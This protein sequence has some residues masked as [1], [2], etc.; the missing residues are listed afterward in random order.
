MLDECAHYGR[1]FLTTLF[2]HMKIFLSYTRSKDLF[3]KISSFRDR[4][5]AEISLRSPGAVV[6]QDKQHL[7]EGGHFPEVLSAELQGADV[8]VPIISPA[9]F[10]SDWCRREFSIFTSDALDN[11]RLHK[12][13]PVL[14]VD[15]PGMVQRSL[16]V[17]ARVLADISY[18]DWRDLRHEEWTS[19]KTQK[20]ISD[21]AES[22]I[23]LASSQRVR[24]NSSVGTGLES[25]RFKFGVNWSSDGVPFCNR[26]SLPL[27]NFTWATF[28]NRQ[29]KAFKCSCHPDPIILMREGEPVHAPDAMR[30]MSEK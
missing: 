15:S 28:F 13:I 22:I 2:A 19:S 18:S 30:E 3:G 24:L 21:L 5:E 20:Q 8:F 27:N 11:L 25:V 1:I 29:V 14:W 17:I 7:S 10:Q 6:F 4:L 9:W 16:D 12:I 26:C 23:S